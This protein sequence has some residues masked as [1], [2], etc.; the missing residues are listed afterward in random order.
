MSQLT[1]FGS[2]TKNIFYLI[3]LDH[4]NNDNQKEFTSFMLQ[5]F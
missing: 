3:D 5:S 2:V 1:L 4:N